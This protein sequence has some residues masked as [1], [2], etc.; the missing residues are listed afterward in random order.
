MSTNSCPNIVYLLAD[1]LGY[2]D[3]EYNGGQAVTPHLKAM[4]NG[5][6]SI[7]FSRFYSG[8]PI[9]SPTRG[10]LL[11]GRNHNRYCIWHADIG[12]GAKQDLTCPSLM[13]LPH[14]EFTVAEIL[15]EIGYCT[16]IYGKWPVGDLV[17]IEGGNEK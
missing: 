15:K 17:P 12:S 11:T 2:G 6:H 10:T 9:C 3:V 16:A 7:H 14:S 4:A 1:D 8:G 13:P 5:P